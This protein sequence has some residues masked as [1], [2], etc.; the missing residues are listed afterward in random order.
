M[1]YEAVLP[2]LLGYTQK[3]QLRTLIY[4]SKQI[5]SQLILLLLLLMHMLLSGIHWI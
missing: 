3:H 4:C 2:D 1:R 5:F